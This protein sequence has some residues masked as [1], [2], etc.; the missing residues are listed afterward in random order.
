[1]EQ[2]GRYFIAATQKTSARVG[3][4]PAR[5]LEMLWDQ[6]NRKAAARDGLAAEFSTADLEG[7][8]EL[9]MPDLPDLPD[10]RRGGGFTIDFRIR[11]TYAEPGQ[12]LLD[13]RAS[14]E[15]P[16]IVLSTGRRQTLELEIADGPRKFRWNTDPFTLPPDK[17]H[18]VSFIVDGGPKIIVSVVDGRL[19]DG[20]DSDE[21]KYGYGRFIQSTYSRNPKENV[22]REEMGEVTGGPRLKVMP[23][24]EKGATL[25][26]LR[27]YSRA[28][29]T[30]EAIGNYREG[31]R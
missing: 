28:I 6:P 14:P 2:N 8:K 22:I 3:E 16:G 21:R 19:S 12:I 25:E 24:V 26:G 29:M 13:S 11:M 9:A 4:V 10:L 18:H 31:L 17:L 23:R 30:T 5:W 27:I 1:V 15:G 20:G 7:G